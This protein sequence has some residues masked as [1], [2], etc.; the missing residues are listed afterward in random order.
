MG[1]HVGA[2]NFSKNSAYGDANKGLLG[3]EQQLNIY[4]DGHSR[5]ART[6][7]RTVRLAIIV[8]EYNGTW[9]SCIVSHRDWI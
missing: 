2:M 6:R 1:F 5:E 3:M 9:T 4:E 8:P 7:T